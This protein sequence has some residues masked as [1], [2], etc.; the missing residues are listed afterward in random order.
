MVTARAKA[1]GKALLSRLVA[2][3]R[4]N[5]VYAA[6]KA[7]PDADDDEGLSAIPARPEHHAVL[8]QSA[9][10][11]MRSSLS[12]ARAG[13]AGLVLVEQGRPVSVAHFAERAQYD[14]DGTWPLD[15]DGV[16][17]MDIATE[18]SQRGRGLAVRLI[19]AA[20]RAYLAQGHKRL[21][22]FI[23]WSNA[24]S[25]RAFSKAGWQRIGMSVEWTIAGRWFAI[26]I[27]TR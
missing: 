5:W 9:T 22:A 14:R 3:Y 7:L 8:A 17:L 24:P 18:E 4:I 27:P 10:P 12:F 26:R 11:K 1:L 23:W 15:S 19:R 21:I 16:A 20:T 2:D 25:I 6:D 13:L